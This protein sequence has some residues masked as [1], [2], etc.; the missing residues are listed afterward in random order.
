MWLV[1]TYIE[2]CRVTALLVK[3]RMSNSK[4]LDEREDK[5]LVVSPEELLSI[6]ESLSLLVNR[7]ELDGAIS[8]RPLASAAVIGCSIDLI[9]KVAEAVLKMPECLDKPQNQELEV[10]DVDLFVLREVA[11]SLVLVDR[12]LSLS[13][14]R[15]IYT[16]LM[17][18]SIED[19]AVQCGELRFVEDLLNR[20][21]EDGDLNQLF[22]DL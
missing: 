9:S 13:L 7:S 1:D 4:S 22:E 19:K 8:L 16:L 14:R 17:R 21:D 11:I 18:P 2:P 3:F 20:A 6:D 12:S 10:S 5:V 15:K